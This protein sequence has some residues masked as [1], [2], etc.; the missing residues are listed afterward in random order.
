MEVAGKEKNRKMLC[1]TLKKWPGGKGGTKKCRAE[2][3]EGSARHS[4]GVICGAPGTL[5]MWARVCGGEP[6]GAR[7]AVRLGVCGW[8]G[9]G[10]RDS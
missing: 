1:E 5:E 4:A 2:L 10:P 8:W 7:C 6:R 9:C 3:W